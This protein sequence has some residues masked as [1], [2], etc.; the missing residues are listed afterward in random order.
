MGQLL[1]AD[2]TALVAEKASMSTESLREG[3]REKELESICEKKRKKLI[4]KWER[5]GLRLR[6]K[7]R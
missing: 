7:L 3:V 5:K 2:K 1:L 4:M 6:C